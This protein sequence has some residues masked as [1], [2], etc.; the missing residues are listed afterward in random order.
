M[1]TLCLSLE[2][3]NK[4]QVKSLAIDPAVGLKILRILVS[5]ILGIY[6]HVQLTS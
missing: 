6:L 3:K 2:E 4:E 5:Y 1:Q